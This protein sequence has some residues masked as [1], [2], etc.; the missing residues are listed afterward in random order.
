MNALRVRREARRAARAVRIHDLEVATGEEPTVT[1]KDTYGL[2]R[3]RV[4]RNPSGAWG[5]GDRWEAAGFQDS[6]GYPDTVEASTRRGCIRRA[7]RRLRIL[8]YNQ[9]V[10]PVDVKP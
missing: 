8:V 10:D 3:V 5:M 4:S 7:R 2:P 6:R 1:D 9:L